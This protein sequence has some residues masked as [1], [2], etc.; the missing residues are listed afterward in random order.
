M[1]GGKSG[2]PR[3][4]NESGERLIW[5]LAAHIKKDVALRRLLHFVDSTRYCRVFPDVLCSFDC[6]VAVILCWCLPIDDS[7]RKRPQ[8][9]N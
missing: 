1:D 2:S 4:G 5:V 6:G 3:R 7:C 8:E 9:S